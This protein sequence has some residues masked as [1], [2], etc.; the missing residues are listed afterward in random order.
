MKQK[1]FLVTNSQDG[2]SKTNT[3]RSLAISPRLAVLIVIPLI[4]ITLISIA[5]VVG[6]RDSGGSKTPSAPELEQR[7]SS[8]SATATAACAQFIDDHV[9]TPCP[10]IIDPDFLATATQACAGFINLFP[11][12][13]C[14]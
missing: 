12:T 6:L 8:L 3:K 7:F 13:P 11:G 9:G 10:P 14:P 2:D 4:L 5:V 1:D